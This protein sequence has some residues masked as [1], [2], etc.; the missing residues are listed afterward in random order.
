[1]TGTGKMG[2]S[3]QLQIQKEWCRYWIRTKYGFC[4]NSALVVILT[5]DGGDKPEPAKRELTQ[6]LQEMRWKFAVPT[7]IHLHVDFA[8]S[9]HRVGIYWDGTTEVRGD[10]LADG[11]DRADGTYSYGMRSGGNRETVRDLPHLRLDGLIES[12]ELASNA[13]DLCAWMCAADSIVFFG[14]SEFRDS[15]REDSI[16]QTLSEVAY[17]LGRPLNRLEKQITQESSQRRRDTEATTS[18]PSDDS[19]G[20]RSGAFNWESVHQPRIPDHILEPSHVGNPV[21]MSYEEGRLHLQSLWMG[22]NRN[23]QNQGE[24]EKS[25]GRRVA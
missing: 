17:G 3:T 19:I 24:A 4:A 8:D 16:F 6:T 11:T 18:E 9:A 22:A 14:G 13:E 10:H 23:T 12:T 1:M 2:F 15:K 20:I 5:A 25:N 7:F 21:K